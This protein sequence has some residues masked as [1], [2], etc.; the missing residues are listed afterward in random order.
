MS[1]LVKSVIVLFVLAIAFLA[2]IGFWTIV[3]FLDERR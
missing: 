2:M 3:L 1:W